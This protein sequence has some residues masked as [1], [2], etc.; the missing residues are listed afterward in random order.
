[1]SSG[2]PADVQEIARIFIPFARSSHLGSQELPH[3]SEDDPLSIALKMAPSALVANRIWHVKYWASR[4]Y[5]DLR[6]RVRCERW[7]SILRH[8][9]TPQTVSIEIAVHSNAGDLQYVPFWWGR[10]GLNFFDRCVFQIPL[11]H[12]LN[13]RPVFRPRGR[14]SN[15]VRPE[16]KWLLIDQLRSLSQFI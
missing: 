3:K 5:N 12:K 9:E 14:K 2:C 11:H 1:M 16:N 13:W 15:R 7:I 6:Y 4:I 8:T 10:E